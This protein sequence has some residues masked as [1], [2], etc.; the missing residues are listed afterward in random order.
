[1]KPNLR[2]RGARN[3][4]FSTC[5]AY[6][7]GLS[8]AGAASATKVYYV[9]SGGTTSTPDT[10]DA[11]VRADLDATNQGIVKAGVAGAPTSVA[12]DLANN[13]ALVPDGFAGVNKIF[14]IDL[15][16]GTVTTFATG[17]I[18]A[19]TDIKIDVA[20][21][22]VYLAVQGG[23]TSTP[24]ATDAL[25]KIT[26]AGVM[27]TV[28][29]NI[30]GAPGALA[31]D[32]ANHRAFVSDAF[33][34][35]NKIMSVDLSNGAV[36]TFATTSSIATALALDSTN[37]RLYYTTNG[38]G[39]ATPAPSDALFYAKLSD[40]TSVTVATAIA[41]NPSELVLDLAGNRALVAD[42]FTGVNKIVAVDLTSGAVSPFL[43]TAAVPTGLTIAAPAPVISS[44]L[45]ASGTVGV[46]ISTYTITASNSPTSFSATGLPGGLNVNAANGQI[47]GTPS[48]SGTFNATIKATNSG[49]SGTATLVYAISA[50]D[51]TP[52]SVSIGAPS[53]SLTKDDPVSYT[54]TYADDHFSSATLATS[55]IT[56]NHTGDAA[57][58][59]VVVTGSGTTRTVTLSGLSG[60]GTL[61]I[62]IAAGT[63]TDTFGNAAPAAGP[64]SAFSVD[65]TPPVISSAAT[66]SGTYGSS[67]SYTIAATGGAVSYGAPVLPPGLGVNATSGLISGTP[68]QPGASD[69]TI[70]ATDALGNTGTAT[71]H[72]TIAKA[73]A[74]IALN[75]GS[76]HATY[77]SSPHAATATTT[78]AGLTLGFTYDA[79]AT[80][81]VNAGS[82]AVSAVI[83]DTNYQGS[84]S[85][86]LV[87][88][89][90]AATVALGNLSVNYDGSPHAATA[91]TT[92]AGLTVGFTYDGSATPPTAVGS[93]A[94]VA[95][96][97]DSNRSGSA[98]GTLKILN[99]APVVAPQVVTT[100]EDT[101]KAITLG[102]SD[103][104]NSP[105]TFTVIT[106]PQHGALSGTA[107][108]L[109]Y[110]PALNY[111]G[112]DSFTFKANDGTTDSAAT[113]TVSITV[114]PVN[115][116][117][118]AGADTIT[119]FPTGS[120]K[121]PVATLLANDTDVDGDTPVFVSAG[122][123]AHGTVTVAN[124][125][126]FYLPN[127]GFL[128]GDSFTYTISDGH[129]GTATGT[130]TVAIAAD[131]DAQAQTISKLEPQPDGSMKITFNGIL[132]ATYRIQ[133]SDTL[134]PGS[135]VD[136]AT[137]TT[138]ALGKFQFTDPAPL[139]ATRFYR[140]VTP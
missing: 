100:S 29:T 73:T 110:T 97:N 105:L 6:V 106:P 48:A 47:T 67:F 122:T 27:S 93:Y 44:T 102:G 98:T 16:S 126:V 50:A 63:A 83:S 18:G 90:A 35:V 82:Y 81:P 25:V 39:G 33:T 21:G 24:S 119:R 74:T 9:T 37:Q 112:T 124:G 68:T 99:N 58:S 22:D 8:G 57:A 54:V 88:D 69:V 85:G 49:G 86:T 114:T 66:A 38:G 51:T 53:S 140:V 95:T 136:R 132:G 12:I 116:D 65:H 78:P 107:P 80:V 123:A 92:P 128:T 19:P 138:D 135:W 4:L 77:D 121:V 41:G 87:I 42:S 64:S 139:P 26:S 52:P 109:T 134:N 31:L 103:V 129:G 118:V 108:N 3:A 15:S 10:L 104:E 133:S 71:L 32:L 96:I 59:S 72:I 101:A 79:S 55:N 115:D 28:A 120:V 70:S 117:P 45:T 2:F 43:T 5:L 130:V 61:S 89:K 75:A 34:G 7:A 30:A 20:T 94:V 60:T 111:H 125:T 23:S 46:P 40:G 14:A 137:L 76:L 113:A 62:T 84:A 91:T 56:V 131:P 127:E 36:S 11:L 17:L 13:R 1:M